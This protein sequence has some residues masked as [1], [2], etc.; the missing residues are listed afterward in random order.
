VTS[1]DLDGSTCIYTQIVRR[2]QI[3]RAKF[4]IFTVTPNMDKLVMGIGRGL[5]ELLCLECFNIHPDPFFGE[6]MNS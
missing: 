3:Q 6:I 1:S 2:V 5:S 4:K